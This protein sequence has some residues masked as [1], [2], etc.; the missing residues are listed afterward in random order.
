MQQTPS[1]SACHVLVPAM[2]DGVRDGCDGR[3]HMLD[4]SEKLPD[5]YITTRSQLFL[6]TPLCLVA[7][8]SVS[9]SASS[10]LPAPSTKA[11]ELQ[12]TLLSFTFPNYIIPV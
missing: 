6:Y 12:P 3:M 4:G 1:S 9:A 10:S 11:H 8:N 2:E 7:S 5:Q